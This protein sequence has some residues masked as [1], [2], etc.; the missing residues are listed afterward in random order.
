MKLHISFATTVVLSQPWLGFKLLEDV[1][2]SRG[3]G[4][5]CHGWKVQILFRLSNTWARVNAMAL[6]AILERSQEIPGGY[7]PSS[8]SDRPKKLGGTP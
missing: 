7:L 2:T 8:V 4:I 3:T 6:R 5:T 1:G